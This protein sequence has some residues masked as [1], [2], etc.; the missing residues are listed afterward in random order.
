MP[1]RYLG[2]QAIRVRGSISGR[3]YIASAN[4]STPLLVDPRD[5]AALVRTG[6]FS[7]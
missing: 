1:L 3:V 4:P 2:S 5:V 6:Y 7:R